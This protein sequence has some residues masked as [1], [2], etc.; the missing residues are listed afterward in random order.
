MI[1]CLLCSFNAFFNN[2]KAYRASDSIDNI[3]SASDD[4]SGKD[5]HGVIVDELLS[6]LV[7]KIDILPSQT[8]VDPCVKTFD[9]NEI[10]I[11]KKRQFGL[12]ADENSSR[13]RRRQ[14]PKKQLSTWT[15][16]CASYRRR[17]LTCVCRSGPV[18]T[19]SHHFDSVDVSSLLQNIC[20][21]QL[22]VDQLKV[23]VDGQVDPTDVVKR[24][25]PAIHRTYFRGFPRRHNQAIPN[26]GNQETK[27]KVFYGERRRKTFVASVTEMM[28]PESQ[29]ASKKQ[30]E[31]KRS[32]STDH[33]VIH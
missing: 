14:G 29:P 4:V 7:N 16:C 26:H 2:G 30:S 27:L 15:I 1:E 33:Y 19:P 6:F 5:N 10:K 8:I 22:E 24:Q 31:N 18:Q 17:A 13:F 12:C 28:H 23:C 3:T 20:R 25:A 9:D 32:R 21:A 11:S